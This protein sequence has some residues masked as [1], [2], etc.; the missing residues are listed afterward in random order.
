MVTTDSLI[1]NIDLSNYYNNIEVDD[2]DYELSTLVLNTYTKTEVDSQLTDYTTITQL[3][4]NYMTSIPITETLM[5]NCA[6]IT[7]L[8][9]NFYTK[10]ETGT[11]LADK[12]SNTGDG[13][14]PGM[15]D[16]GISGYTKSR[17]RCNADI[18]GY[19]GYAELRAAISYDMFVNLSTTRTDGGWMYFKINHDD[20]MQLSSS[21]N[22][23]I[24]YKRYINKWKFICWFNR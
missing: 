11:F 14:L 3:Q 19:T 13:S 4:G 15:L 6:T 10:A 2:I 17:I 16:I 5:N 24:S 22:K 12:V 21:D 20:Y 23:E 1:S 8:E 7:L 18:G 9:D